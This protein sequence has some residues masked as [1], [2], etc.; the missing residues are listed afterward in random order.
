YKPLEHSAFL[1]LIRIILFV[2][3][4]SPLF[5]QHDVLKL[6]KLTSDDGLSQNFI[7]A[8]FQDKNGFMWFGTKDGLNRYDG[9]EFKVYRHNPFDSTSLSGNFILSLFEDS[10]GRLWVGSSM[11]DLFV[12]ETDAFKRININKLM[13][14]GDRRTEINKIISITEDNDGLIWL[15]T[16]DGLLSY[17]PQSEA[18]KLYLQEQETAS[19][20]SDNVILS[21]SSDDS[22]LFVG[23]Q[24]GMK[25]L[26]LDSIK[27]NKIKFEKIL[28]PPATEILTS[29]RTILSQFRSSTNI[30]YA[31][32][33]SG[34]IKINLSTRES[35]FIQYRG[36]VFFPYWLNR[37][38]SIVQD[39]YSNL[40]FACSGGLVI[41]NPIN[42][43]FKYYFHNPKDD[44][45]LSLNNITS[46]FADRGGKI[47]IG[48]AGKG[49]NLFDQN[50]KEFLLYDGLIDEEPYKS[51]FSVSAILSENDKYLW[52]ASQQKLF[53]LN[54]TTGE[55]KR[56]DLLYGPEGEISSV[57]KDSRQNIWVASSGGL[58]KIS[59][60]DERIT[61]YSHN[62]ANPKSLED[63]FVRLL[64]LDRL[65]NLFALNSR[66]LSKFNEES[67]SF[68]H[69]ELLFT[70]SLDPNPIIRCIY[71]SKDGSLWF[72][73]TEGLV[74]YNL[75]TQEKTVYNHR[76][77]DNQSISNNEV[78][79][80]C[81]D[82]S[83]S[84]KFL[85]VGTQ[86]GGLSRLNLEDG[87]FANFSVIDGLPNNVVYG[88]LSSGSEL[89][90][91]T[92]NGLCKVKTD[93]YGTPAFRNYDVSDG[94]QGNEFNTGAY[95]KSSSGELFFGGLNGVN[96][97]FPSN[98]RDNIY[99]PPVVITELRFLNRTD[100][101]KNLPVQ[102]SIAGN[103]EEVTIP[104][105][106]N[107][108]T[109]VFASLDYTAPEKNKYMYKLDPIH[110]SWINLGTQR[111]H[112][113]KQCKPNAASD[114]SNT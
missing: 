97:F 98:I 95:S 90:V 55:Y 81:E 73:W 41:Y 9:Y 71:E 77:G 111:S 104:Y 20:L 48:T 82:P 21:L 84:D 109:V 106:Q 19:P 64:F 78:L 22:L 18:V 89:W 25:L 94:L 5:S 10:K 101:K 83:Q 56:I 3:I 86:G 8:I 99:V 29:K 11:L 37:I 63:N 74:K 58:H 45:S 14:E 108:F 34:L 107:S 7:S 92:N 17:D 42:N 33:P 59:G 28:H 65:G 85:W 43:S 114:Q 57:V 47:W 26:N 75:E 54:R 31:G 38:L 105:S 66:Y 6:K 61:Y 69:Y 4:T 52:I 32:T 27:K 93:K 110:E 51:S 60:N 76:P 30:I 12:P 39:K 113:K 49:I 87:T 40:W 70:D 1:Y 68:T 62:S 46:L 2:L 36:Y 80:I 23:T 79:T 15:G 35:E 44:Q 72:G 96:A 112:N 67:N 16:N 102:L 53:K 24:N 50:K 100:D 13:T 91:S 88:I 103:K